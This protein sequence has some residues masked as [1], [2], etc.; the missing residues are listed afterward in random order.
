MSDMAEVG[1]VPASMLAQVIAAAN[2]AAQAH[3]GQRRKGVAQEPYVNHVLEVTQMLAQATGGADPALL[4]GGL[5]HDTVE[6][7][8]VT[9]AEIAD[10][11]GAKVAA[12]VAEVT[13]DKSLPKPE[14]KQ[15]QVTNAPHK[16]DRAK[17]LKLADKTSNL[18][19][20]L[21]SPPADWAIE[22]K[23]EYFAWAKQVADGLR[24]VN[25][26]LEA[27]FDAAYTEGVRAFK[28]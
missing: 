22:R 2:F 25:A 23:R 16:S 4:M 11:F 14:R 9:N 15:L 19:A 13:D 7:C 3:S 27:G 20:V 26:E 21:N 17:M 28:K 5:L 10:T 18:R 24:G 6:D 1:M 8:G 12:L